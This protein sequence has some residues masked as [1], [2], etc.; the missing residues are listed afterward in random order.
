MS[1]AGDYLCEPRTTPWLDGVAPIVRAALST[2]VHADVCVIGGGIAGVT[3]AYLLA[4]EGASVVLLERR[5]IGSGETGR[6]TAHLT[7]VMDDRFSV[8]EQ[9]FGDAGARAAGESHGV[10]IDCIEAIAAREGIDCDFER[11][12][13]YLFVPP[14]G[15]GGVLDGELDAARRAGLEVERVSRAP[16]PEYDTGPCLRFAR[17]GQFHPLKYLD[18]IV[19]AFE[20]EGGKLF[21]H[22][23]VARVAGGSYPFVST[24]NGCVVEASAIVVATNTPIHDNLLVHVKQSPYRTYAIGMDVRRGAVPRALYWD[25]PDPYHYVRLQNGA[26]EEH[27]LVIVGGEDHRCGVEDDGE[28]RFEAL[29]EWTRERF[30]VAGARFCWSGQV[31]EPADGPGLIGRDR[32]DQPN[33]YLATGDSGQGMTHGT[34]A[35]LLL[36]D[37][38]LG[39]PNAWASLY[40]PSRVPLQSFDFVQ[41]NVDTLWHYAEWFTSGDV[42]DAGALDRGDG[43][44]IRRG[45]EKRALYRDDDGRL[46]DHS[47]VCPHLG[48]VV[49]WNSG[50]RMWHCPCHGSRFFCDGRL[51]GGPAR[52]DL[53]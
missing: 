35:G 36:R 5:H 22:T 29:A 53:S 47:A 14:G 27:E 21:T 10:A 38:I 7:N 48:C 43:A 46:H 34:V 28:E 41:E 31:M 20:K 51:A 12:D 4:R 19:R 1:V 2:N 8:L 40:D 32:F 42:G 30:P 49:Q 17:Q 13:G 3:T 25:T 44:V 11:L 24:A 6:T 26:D 52:S 39:R 45:L 15:D 33:V 50:E 16:L 18:G 23:H 37:L 9:R